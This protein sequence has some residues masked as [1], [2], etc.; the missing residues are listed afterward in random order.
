MSV[1]PMMYVDVTEKMDLYSGT[2][3]V[4]VTMSGLITVSA[5]GNIDCINDSFSHIFLGYT[6]SDLIGKV[7]PLPASATATATSLIFL[8]IIIRVIIE[9]AF[10]LNFTA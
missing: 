5:D 7:R 1:K 4:Y 8:I 10:Q 6:C 3:R 9:T 2:V